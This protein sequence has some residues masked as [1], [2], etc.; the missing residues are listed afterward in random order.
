V[1]Y[2]DIVIL[3][4]SDV[5]KAL[6]R[7]TTPRQLL[8]FR[9][10]G[11]LDWPLGPSLARNP[12]HLKAEAALIKRFMQNA[13]PYLPTPVREE[14]E[15]MFLMQHHRAPTRLLD[16]TESPLTA[17][18]FA[19][20]ETINAR[21]TGAVWCLDPV[22]LN[23]AANMKFDFEAEIPAFGR[24]KVL[25]S[26]LPSRVQESPS[27]LFPVAIVGPRNTPRM[28]AQSGT[29]TVN[30]RLHTPI[31]GINTTNDHVWRWKIPGKAKKT[32]RRELSLLGYSTLSLFPELDSVAAQCKELLP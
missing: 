29:F 31:E 27:E 32:L 8:W 6:Q 9:G 26:Y 23:R 12:R 25:E 2:K 16:W 5:M 19:V 14:W 3:S 18:S 24:D 4:L 30:H 28:T 17:L 20:S 13:T 15:W 21:A 10:H 11:R 22:A 7:Q 1:R